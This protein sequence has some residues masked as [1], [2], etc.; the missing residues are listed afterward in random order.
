MSSFL[1]QRVL[2][3]LSGE[4]LMGDQGFGLSVPVLD[5]LA[6]DVKEIHAAGIEVAFVVGG[7]NSGL[8][9][10]SSLQNSPA[11]WTSLSTHQSQKP[12][13]SCRTK[14]LKKKT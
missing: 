1:Y 4:A 5:R 7:G 2:L 6:H 11:R 13:R 12:A 3:K 10:G 14:W 8:K 9:K